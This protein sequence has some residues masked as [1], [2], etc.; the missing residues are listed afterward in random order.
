LEALAA[1]AAAEPSGVGR[2]TAIATAHGG[3]V[4]LAAA[5]VAA[6][7]GATF[8]AGLT[9]TPL[10]AAAALVGTAMAVGAAPP[11]LAGRSIGGSSC[12]AAGRAR[13]P[14]R[15]P[16]LQRLSYTPKHGYTTSMVHLLAGCQDRLPLPASFVGR[17]G[18]NPSTSI[19]VEEGSGG[20][21]LYLIEILHDKQGKSYFTEGWTKF[22]D[23]YDLKCGWSLILTHRAGSPILCVRVVNAS[24]CARAYSPWL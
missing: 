21:P 18:K 10:E 6:P 4:A 20:Q 2:S 8:V 16:P 14:Q 13:K 12:A 5:N 17:M 3:A 15:P 9:G 1:V 7:A 23:D 19:K 22:L 11:G 24:G